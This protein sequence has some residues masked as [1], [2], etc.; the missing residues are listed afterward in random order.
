M[1]DDHKKHTKGLG[2]Q[3]PTLNHSECIISQY[4][5]F[6]LFNKTKPKKKIK[7]GFYGS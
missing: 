7:R 1:L 2:K 4:G 5:K 6:I 3:S